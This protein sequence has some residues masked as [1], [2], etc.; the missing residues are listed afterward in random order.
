MNREPAFPHCSSH[1]YVF[2][3]DGVRNAMR[4]QE[5]LDSLEALE[6]DS[7]VHREVGLRWTQPEVNLDFKRKQC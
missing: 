7:H 5:D 6:G 4:L 1:L 3:Q 2:D